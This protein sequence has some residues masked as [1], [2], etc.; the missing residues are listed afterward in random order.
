MG[1][2]SHRDNEYGQKCTRMVNYYYSELDS[3]LNRY[4]QNNTIK[5]SD[6]YA[7]YFES[8]LHYLTRNKLPRN[9]NGT[10]VY[11]YAKSLAWLCIYAMRNFSLSDKDRVALQ[12]GLSLASECSGVD[13]LSFSNEYDINLMQFR[14]E[15]DMLDAMNLYRKFGIYK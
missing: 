3:P 11:S 6:E 4:F 14:G 1:L 13:E 12:K 8:N 7:C 9:P 5:R 10:N 15:I 2:F